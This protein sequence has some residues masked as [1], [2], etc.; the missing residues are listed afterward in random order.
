[1]GL[2]IL[3]PRTHKQPKRTVGD[4]L[5]E[6][7][8][9]AGYFV[10]GYF[11]IDPFSGNHGRKQNLQEIV[12]RLEQDHVQPVLCHAPPASFSPGEHSTD[13]EHGER[14]REEIYDEIETQFG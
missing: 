4:G 6:M 10:D 12:D 11:L 13:D 8:P 3:L 14:G 9:L 7:D 1:M 2:Q 5:A